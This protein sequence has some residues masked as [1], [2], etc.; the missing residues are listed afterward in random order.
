MV[1]IVPAEFTNFN[2]LLVELYHMSP[3]R[4]AVGSVVTIGTVNRCAVS[5]LR[6]RLKMSSK[7]VLKSKG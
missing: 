3:L 7:N 6:N 2:V 4:G 1:L 5:S